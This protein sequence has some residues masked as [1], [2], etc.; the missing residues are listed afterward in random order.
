LDSE[1]VFDSDFFSLEGLDELA[2]LDEL[3]DSAEGLRLSVM[4]QPDPLKMIPVG[5]KILRTL[6]DAHLGHWRIGAS[7]TDWIFSK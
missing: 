2:E 7:C 5:E 1:L 4:Y 6:S 3:E